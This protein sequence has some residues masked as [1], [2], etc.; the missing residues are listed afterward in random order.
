MM[1]QGKVGLITGG[2]AG[3]GRAT[4]L[5]FARDGAKVAVAGRRLETVSETVEMILEQ[6]GE[7]VA[8]EADVSDEAAVEAM[9]QQTVDAFGRID[10][11]CNNAASNGGFGPLEGVDGADWDHT[12]SV[13]LRGVWLCMK[14]EIPA[15]LANGG[16]SIVNMSSLAGVKGEAM[17]TPY[18]AA[19]GGVL[20]L[21]R[22]AASENAQKGIRI[23]A[24]N[25]GA[26]RTRALE[27]Y[28][29]S[30]PGAEETTAATHAMRR[31]GEPDEIADAVVYLCSDRSSFV[32]GHA[33]NVDGGVMVNSH[34]L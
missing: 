30:V 3:I 16:G 4:S 11:A 32:T 14:Y 1:L 34:L 17:L 12:Q 2:G 18:S 28:F 6:G 26:V 20:A 21:T 27:G 9:V 5:M 22:A 15:M 33:L 19:K 25:P 29:T 8:I 31:V 10:C 7:A 23:N 13:T 24:I